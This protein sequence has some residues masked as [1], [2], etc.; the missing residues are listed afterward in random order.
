MSKPKARSPNNDTYAV[1]YTD[2]SGESHTAHV[3][4][5]DPEHAVEG[6]RL[7]IAWLETLPPQVGSV[8]FVPTEANGSSNGPTGEPAEPASR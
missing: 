1:R 6:G 3:R 2:T 7:R 4:Y 5:E 8:E